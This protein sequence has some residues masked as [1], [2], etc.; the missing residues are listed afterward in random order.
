MILT[1]VWRPT[2]LGDRQCAY[3]NCRRPIAEHERAVSGVGGMRL[4]MRPGV[5]PVPQRSGLVPS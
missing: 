5:V 4:G 1:H 2:P 3:L